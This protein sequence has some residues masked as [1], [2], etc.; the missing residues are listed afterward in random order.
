[1][2]FGKHGTVVLRAMVLIVSLALWTAGCGGGGGSNNFS[3]SSSPPPTTNNTSTGTNVSVQPADANGATPAKLTFS[4][5]TQGGMTS[6]TMA[7]TGAA[8]PAGFLVGNPAQYFDLSTTAVFSGTVTVCI[9]YTAI[10][11]VNSPRLF[12][13][14]GSA[15]VDVT[16]SVDTANHTVCGS[17]TSFSPFAIFQSATAPAITSAGSAAFMVGTA[18]SFTVTAIGFPTPTLTEVGSLPNGLSFTDNH[19]GTAKLS[20]TATVPGNFPITITAHNGAAPDTTQ[21]F[22]LIVNQAAAITSANNTAFTLGSLSSFT[23]T[24]TGFPTP[25]LSESGALPAGVTFNTATGVLSGTPTASGSF[26]ISFTAHNGVGTDAVQN[27][28]LTV[29]QASSSTTIAS[30]LNPSTFGAAVTFTATV[31]S[32]GGT[33]TGTVTFKDGT[34][35][36]GTGTLTSGTATFNTSTLSSGP[37][38]I[39][40]LYGGDTNFQASTSS[41]LSQT[42]NQASSATAVASSLNPS[43]FGAAVTFTATVTSTG[44]T[45]T[46]TVTFKDGSTTLGTATLTSGT[47]TFNTSTLATGPHVIT[48]IYGGDSNFQSSTSAAV[49]QTVSQASSAT[50]VASSLN[51]STFGAA[52]T[53]TA[54]VTSTSGSPTGTVTFKDGITTLGTGALTSGQA[55]FNTSTLALGPHAINAV[56]GG[57]TNF[58]SSTSSPLT[59]TVNQA[60]SS[61]AVASSLNP[62]T[63]GAAVT[64]TATVTSAGGTPTGTVTFQGDTTTLGTGTLASGRATFNTSTLGIGSHVITA[65]YGG[66]TNFH[67]SM[68]SPLNQAVNQSPVIT[69]G[70]NTTFKVGDAGSFN[71]IATGFP[72]PNLTE[73]G[74]LPHDVTFTDNHDSTATLR[75]TP[76]VS[77]SFPITI[78]AHNGVIPDET[79]NFTLTVM[80][81]TLQSITINAISGSI[82]K[83]TTDQFTATGSFSDGT[84]Q[85]LST[86]VTWKSDNPGVASI[87]ASGL[88]TGASVGSANISASRSGITSNTLPLSVTP[89]TLGSITISAAEPSIAK[90]TSDQF[91]AIGTFS[92]G[93]TQDLTN[94]VSWHSSN[95]SAAT[96]TANGLATGVSVGSSDI[97]ATQNGVTSGN[98]PLSVTPAVLESIVISAAKTS[99]AKGT[100][101]PFTAI[102]TFSDGSTQ[103]LTNAATWNSS[104]STIAGINAAGVA[105]GISLGSTDISATQSGV[106]SNKFT[107]T[108]TPAV[109]QSI[110]IRA[111]HTSI[112][113]GTSI[114]FTAIG[115]F[116]DGTTQDLTNSA[117]W[118]SLTPNV[119]NIDN[120]GMATGVTVGLSSITASKGGVTSNTFS[121]AV[122]AAMLQSISVSPTSASIVKGLTQQFTAK[123]TFTDG[124]TQDL[125]TSVIWSSSNQAVVNITDDGLATAVTV[126][127]S[128]ITAAQHGISSDPTVLTVLPATPTITWANPAAITYGTAL[129]ASQ[130]NATATVPG[131]FTYMPPAGT[132][133]RAGNQT[134]SVKFTPADTVN[135]ETVT[136]SVSVNVNLAVLTVTAQNASRTY[137]AA[138]PAFS[139]IITG[140]VNGDTASVVSGTAN[141][142]TTAT[143]ASNTGSYPITATAGTLT[144]AN[145][146]FTFVNGTLTVNAAVLTVTAQNASRTYGAANPAVTALITGFV[147]GD[148]QSVVSGTANLSTTATPASGVGSYAITTTA[149]TLTAANYTFS[150]VNGTLTVNAAV[151]T[152][153]AQNASRTYGAANPAF[154]A[155]I[156]GFVNGNTQSV[157]SG[158]PGFS[159]TATPASNTGSY[160][161]TATAG[162]L[163]A[164]N[165]TFTFVNGTLTVNAAVLTVTAQNASRTYGAA[166]PTFTALITGF[167]NGDTQSVVSGTANLSTTATQASGVGS[168][169]ITVTAGT[170]A[171]ANYTFTFVNGTLTITVAT[172]TV[173]WNSP[174]AV[175]YGTALSSTQLNATASVQGSFAYTP[176]A[177]TVLNAGANQT[178]SVTFTPTD[179]T[180]YTTQTATVTITV[181]PATSSTTVSSSLNPSTLGS[182]VTFTATVSVSGGTP[183]GTMMFNDGSTSLGTATLVSGQA[184]FSTSLLAAGPHSITAVY[185]GDTNFLLSTSSA[186]SQTVQQAATITSANNTAFTLDTA[187]SFTVTATGFPAPS[188]SESGTLPTGVT[189]VA[190]SGVLSGTPSVSGSF[191]ITITAHNGVSTDAVQSF[192]LTV[193]PTVLRSITINSVS[194]SIAKGTN[195]Q[196]TATGTLSDGT[197]KDLTNSATWAST[198]T[199]AATVSPTGSAF[200]VDVG[201]TSISATSDGITS[202]I[203]PL[204]V[205]AAVL[206]SLTISTEKPSIAKDTTDLFNAVGVFNDGT[207]Q[208]LTV[209]VTWSSS[210]PAVATINTGGNTAGLATGAGVGSSN[211]TASFNG[212][213]SNVLLLTVTPA[214]LQSIVIHSQNGSIAKGTIDE[215][216]A[217]GT[218]SDGSSQNLTNSVTWNS[219]NPAAVKINASGVATGVNAGSSNISASQNG[220]AS[221]TITL[222][223]TAAV[224]KSIIIGADNTPI[225]KGT[226]NQFIALGT[227]SDG[228]LQDL[229]D[230]ANWVS[231]DPGAAHVGATGLVTGVSVGSCN[232]SATQNGVTSNSFELTIT[233]AVLKAIDIDAASKSTAKGTTDQFTAVGVFTD[234]TTQDLTESATWTSSNP[235]VATIAPMGLVTAVA[236]GTTDIS[237]T[238]NGTTSNTYTLTL[239]DTVLR[240]ITITSDNATIAKGTTNQFT[241]VGHFSDGTTQDLTNSVVWASSDPA[242][243]I[244]SS[245]LANGL[246]PGSS[247]ISATQNAIASNTLALAVSNA[248]VQSITIAAANAS[249]ANGLTEQF[250]ATAT[251]IDGTSQN[252][253][254]SAAWASSNT[255][256]ATISN[257]GV[258]T[259]VTVGST[260]ITGT[261]NGVMSMPFVL[262]VT[263]AVLQSIAVNPATPSIL[264]G[265][266]QQF[267]ASG[268][269][270]DGSTQDVTGL[271][272]WTSSD[273]TIAT[274]S[275]AG[276]ATGV[277]AGSVTIT[278]AENGVSGSTFLAVDNLLPSI[279]SLFPSMLPIAATAQPLTIN[280]SNFDNN[281]TVTYNGVAHPATFIN[282]NQLAIQLSAV[283]LAMAGIFPVVVTNAQPGGGSSAA[284]FSVAGLIVTPASLDFGLVPDGT[285]SLFQIGTLMAVGAPVT[286]TSLSVSNNA[287]G[288]TVSGSPMQF[289]L[290]LGIGDTFPF[291]I[292][293]NPL[294]DSPGPASGALTFVGSTNVAVQPISGTGTSVVQLTWQSSPTP[295]V[296][297]NIYRCGYGWPLLADARC[298]TSQDSS[299]YKY[300]AT[301]SDGLLTYTDVSLSSGKYYYI[302][303]AIDTEGDESDKS[304]VSNPVT[305]P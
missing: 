27:L 89:A 246:S 102:G 167:V 111:D 40:A 230:S 305:V 88:A 101:V 141:L 7:S 200:G 12:H 212:I 125:T 274:I 138:N 116:S 232:I 293:F 288:V 62:S 47:A 269:F 59:Q 32:T 87:S 248:A 184:A 3:S 45:P 281:S 80:P 179:S 72:I 42:V 148:T 224:L 282:G 241:A 251:L 152:V 16:I 15:W 172:P 118:T 302:V 123:G 82:A 50:A 199:A 83:G 294:L 285:A 90:G 58:Q 135:Y 256:V 286:V 219:L 137:G 271:V 54:T 160:P 22:T 218:F 73:A 287:F 150:F 163:T 263:G 43:T 124:T 296:R 237:A 276:L 186:L 168:Y 183:T 109:L 106:T 70:N 68:S 39:T 103:D 53:F 23:V 30:S 142:S 78:T 197:T 242:V 133:L 91:T 60:S 117:I 221:N 216:T 206:H 164:A 165:Y 145:Y 292:T 13:Y 153:T 35:T 55:T 114:Q 2:M 247:N 10:T 239:T 56:Y 257:A 268:T 147:N 64:F 181:N 180:D 44:G 49:S 304:A 279:T 283:D 299:F 113:K 275:T 262:T 155:L 67:S 209:S 48:A 238:Q 84:T 214:V 63:F 159:T 161:I 98:F 259:G 234:G 99:I 122:T 120:G 289:P 225:A 94:S 17:V 126:G 20:G 217:I 11:F 255:A 291:L 213:T 100:S 177:G 204:T 298:S 277:R 264:K 280:G 189:F 301:V 57:D 182:S 51:P 205:T 127:S 105:T 81:A 112:A 267:T 187:N 18:G 297:Y 171:A 129:S 5:V 278:A 96:I 254:H 253:T 119:V 130:L 34:T 215:L 93:T 195:D 240:S 170:L 143:P 173:V 25:T 261:E 4:N 211:I 9:N 226:S 121:L 260:N 176:P 77:G 52:V 79:Q 229:T 31:T 243:N 140:F 28:A 222:A 203:L 134:L 258:A 157:V 132:V 190:A 6:L 290:Q 146:T 36:L 33:P 21:N 231:S 92:D 194:P 151:L 233:A 210:N 185:S 14:N 65:V 192:T 149:G 303:T 46:G 273:P 169:A 107:L 139:A 270:S 235:A 228:T 75:G 37:H 108:V 265:G 97:S 249:I 71:V 227:F 38:S 266:T 223:V 95:E 86:V 104:D 191:P 154:S 144:A 26:P 250:T 245:G 175:T 300:I 236:V 208:D 220:V 198:N 115:T 284:S 156:T 166:N 162:T 24:A 1:M 69:S 193:S 158:T 29:N 110:M 207:S 188:F 61:T 295:G 85:D 128:N 252:V 41:A 8:P 244:N 178:L 66:D 136:T 76:T 202:N 196:F 272:T 201:S 74:T 174:A 19:D 131:S